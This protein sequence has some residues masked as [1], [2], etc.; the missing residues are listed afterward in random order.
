[1]YKT[2]VRC[3]NLYLNDKDGIKRKLHSVLTYKMENGRKGCINR[4]KNAVLAMRNIVQHYL[5]TGERLEKYRRDFKIETKAKTKV[6][7]KTKA[8]VKTKTKAQV[9]TKTKAQVKTKTKTKV[10]TKVK[11]KTKTEVK[12]K[13]KAEVKT[14]P[15]NLKNK[16]SARCVLVKGKTKTKT[17]VETEV[18]TKVVIEVETEVETKVVIK[19]KT[20]VE[21]EEKTETVNSNKKPS[22]RY[23]LVK[24]KSK[25]KKGSNPKKESMLA[26]PFGT[27]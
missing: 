23:V 16:K 1:M 12:T 17:E 3:E 14:N 19:I 13:T 20:K 11:A 9:K 26:K 6:K 4:D 21:T 27:I 18:E 8:Q 24:G 5:K 7:A 10:K 22:G 25:K 2:Q 15:E